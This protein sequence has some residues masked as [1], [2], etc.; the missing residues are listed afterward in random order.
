M[1][2]LPDSGNGGNFRCFDRFF[3]GC[4]QVVA[5]LIRREGVVLYILAILLDSLANDR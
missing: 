5:F 4:G 1:L 3:D 2:N